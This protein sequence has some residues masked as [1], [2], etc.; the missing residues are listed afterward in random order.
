MPGLGKQS[1]GVSV[2]DACFECLHLCKSQ[3]MTVLETEKEFN[4]LCMSLE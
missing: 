2:L 3:S 1:G 4:E